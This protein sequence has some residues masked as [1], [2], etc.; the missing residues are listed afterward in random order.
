MP[1]VNKNLSFFKEV[2]SIRKACFVK[3]EILGL[4]VYPG[5]EALLNLWIDLFHGILIAKIRSDIHEIVNLRM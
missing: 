2:P 5:L 4:E 3:L 1:L